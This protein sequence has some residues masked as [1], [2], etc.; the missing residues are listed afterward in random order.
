MAIVESEHGLGGPSNFAFKYVPS[1]DASSFKKRGNNVDT[2]APV[3]LLS[4]RLELLF[5]LL[6]FLYLSPLCIL[7]IILWRLIL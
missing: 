7:T 4:R 2:K 5:C 3:S 6:F 1:L